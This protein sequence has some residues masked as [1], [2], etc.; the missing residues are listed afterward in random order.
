[1]AQGSPFG[2]DP[3]H[4]LPL[5]APPSDMPGF[6][7]NHAFWLFAN[8]GSVFINAHLNSVDHVWPLRRE[9]LT[10]CLTD[11]RALV[12]MNEG[13]GTSAET[14]ASGGMRA[15]C[16][17]PMRVWSL[18]YKGTMRET[19][20]DQLAASALADGEGRRLL[21]EWEARI[22]CDTPLLRQGR[23]RE[24]YEALMAS[25]ALG[26]MGGARYEQLGSAKVHL[27]VHGDGEYAFEATCTRT[28]RAG[29]RRLNAWLR[30]EWQS[31]LFP[32]DSGFYLQR[33]R[34]DDDTIDWEEACVLRDGIWHRAAIH[35]EN[36]L[37]TR[38]ARGR[39]LDIVLRSDLGES[40][41]RGGIVSSIFR[42]APIDPADIG[43]R[44][45]GP[46]D[47]RFGFDGSAKG[48]VAVEQSCVRYEMDGKIA[49]GLSERHEYAGRCGG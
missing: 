3:A 40:R 9:A 43:A 48:N 5:L 28:H 46:F 32:D 6:G 8:N 30:A 12:E 4:D 33:Y 38:A 25:N 7:E 13:W 24:D 17:E 18:A 22:T 11:G 36:R 19:T 1:M 16:I 37:A 14:I 49:H 45:R 35:S 31:A 42:T 23:T 34:R 27:T 2:L 21:V 44:E 29:V 10:L 39:E 20:Q 15:T 47:R 26:L 41:I